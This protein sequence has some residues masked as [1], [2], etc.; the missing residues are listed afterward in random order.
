MCTRAW[1][2]ESGSRHEQS[3][4]R[5]GL[6]CGRRRG[7][8]ERRG[9]ESK[10]TAPGTLGGVLEVVVWAA[11]VR[12]EGKKVSSSEQFFASS[13][14]PAIDSAQRTGSPRKARSAERSNLPPSTRPNSNRRSRVVPL[15][16]GV[17]CVHCERQAG[18]AACGRCARLRCASTPRCSL[19]A[20]CTPR[21]RPPVCPS[22][23][24]G[25]SRD[26]AARA[27][28]ST[29]PAHQHCGRPLL[30]SPLAA[31][32]GRCHVLRAVCGQRSPPWRTEKRNADPL[33][34]RP[35]PSASTAPLAT[36]QSCQI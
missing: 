19:M 25:S 14:W 30:S 7:R 2:G 28:T 16:D 21:P 3:R 1:E 13:R 27:E 4:P 5:P 20:L 15:V 10:R 9:R 34:Y 24:P 31:R 33:T 6:T 22:H 23:S 8:H 32:R 36:G 18:R 35:L 12:Q 11:V 29:S 26:L 17:H